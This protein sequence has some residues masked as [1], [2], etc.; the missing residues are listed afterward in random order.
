MSRK[1][2]TGKETA[3][4]NIQRDVEPEPVALYKSPAKEVK[5]LL[6]A[7]PSIAVQR[8]QA[9]TSSSLS[10]P[11][12][13]RGS[14]SG[15]SS[16]DGSLQTT[17]GRIS[18]GIQERIQTLEAASAS[19][20]TGSGGKPAAPEVSRTEPDTDGGEQTESDSL[21]VS[22]TSDDEL[23]ESEASQEAGSQTDDGEEDPTE[24]AIAY[25]HPPMFTGGEKDDPKDWLERFEIAAR[26]NNWNDAAKVNQ[27][28]AY[29]DGTA[30]QWYNNAGNLPMDWA[31]TQAAGN[32][33][34]VTGLRTAFLN[35]FQSSDY[36]RALQK[37]LKTRRQTPKEKLMAY[38]WDVIDLCKKVD[39]NMSE[40]DQVKHATDGLLPKLKEKIIPYQVTTKKDFIKHAKAVEAAMEKETD[41]ATDEKE[42]KTENLSEILQLVKHLVLAQGTMSGS[43]ST[44]SG[45]S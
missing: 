37:K 26:Q 6:Q 11:D 41:D 43:R 44:D 38:F 12:A 18:P 25:V 9:S 30:R 13:R 24:M 36:K 20:A 14:W 15:S 22:E 33:A 31:D 45:H 4:S 19:A 27:F 29:M 32:Q 39:P 8:H 1:A 3:R 34:A 28:G 16:Y 35:E 23:Q 5:R 10:L 2:R 21:V 40:A 42:P 7:N 17:G